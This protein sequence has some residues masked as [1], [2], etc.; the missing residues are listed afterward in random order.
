M[1]ASHQV[2]IFWNKNFDMTY[3]S[4]HFMHSLGIEMGTFDSEGALYKCISKLKYQNPRIFTF[5][6][7]QK[8]GF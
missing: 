2:H 5:L 6:T 3:M 1:L 7:A 4:H 8:Y